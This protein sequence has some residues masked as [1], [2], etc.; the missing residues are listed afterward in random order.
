MKRIAFLFVL[1]TGCGPTVQTAIV[2][3][4]KGVRAADKSCAAVV[5]SRDVPDDVARE[6]GGKCVAAYG[7]ARAALLAAEAANAAGNAPSL[8]C[9]STRA[10]SG[11]AQLVSAVRA[12]GVA[13]PPDVALATSRAHWLAKLGEGVTCGR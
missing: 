5:R 11:L 13:V 9:A 4:A 12:A 2:D 7:V 1:L 10:L 8:V 3:V 6:V